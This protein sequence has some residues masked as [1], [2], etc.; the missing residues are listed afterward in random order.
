MDS[1]ERRRFATSQRGRRCSPLV[2]REFESIS[3]RRLER[4]RLEPENTPDC[5]PTAA[6][7]LCAENMRR[8]TLRRIERAEI[9]G[10]RVH[11]GVQDDTIGVTRARLRFWRLLG[12]PLRLHGRTPDK[13]A[14]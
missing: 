11:V 3:L 14:G 1:Y 5:P 4:V 8:S 13:A 10:V 9:K 6:H 12:E 2:N 7:V